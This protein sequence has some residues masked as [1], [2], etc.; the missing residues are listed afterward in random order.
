MKPADSSDPQASM[1]NMMK[2][3]YDE[4]DDD[5]KRQIKKT[6]FESQQNKQNGGGAGGIGGMPG[7]GGAGMPGMPDFGGM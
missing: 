6:W 7:M 1:M 5:M 2:N 3:M 4:G